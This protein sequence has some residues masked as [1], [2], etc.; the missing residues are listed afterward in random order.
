MSEPITIRLLS[1]QEAGEQIEALSAVLIDCVEGGAS[2]SFMSPLTRERADA[3]WQGVAEGVAR[4]ERIL[5]VAQEAS[6]GIVGTVQVV[7]KQPENQPHR[8]DIAKMLVHGQA[9]KRGIGAALMRA[10]EDAARAAGKTVLVLDTVTGGDAE[11]LYERIGWT[12]SGVI[13]NYALWPK[14]G[15][16]D[17]TVFYKQLSAG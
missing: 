4:G 14:G 1:A 17:T 2:V 11:R 6:G 9:R 10:A 15:F 7:L 3:F 8:A 13:P 16:C 12:R 5:L